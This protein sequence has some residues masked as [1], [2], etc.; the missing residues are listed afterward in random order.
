VERLT[1]DGLDILDSYSG[2]N[3]NTGLLVRLQEIRSCLFV[4]NPMIARLIAILAGGVVG[5]LLLYLLASGIGWAWGS[6][7]S[8][9]EDM[10]RNVKLFLAGSVIAAIA[11]GWFAGWLHTRN[12]TL[13]SRGRADHPSP[14]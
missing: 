3:L 1:F 9:E 7:Y 6:F 14:R 12:L 8:N 10:A 11:G 5:V 4:A 2:W 13:R